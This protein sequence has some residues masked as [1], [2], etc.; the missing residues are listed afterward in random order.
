MLNKRQLLPVLLF[1]LIVLLPACAKNNQ[2]AGRKVPE[3]LLATDCGFDK[4]KC[5]A[6]TP[7]CTYGQQCCVDPND[8][9]R[10][11]C[12]DACACGSNDEFCC[13]GNKCNG[14]AVC[15]NGLCSACGDKNQSCCAAGASCQP[16]LICL[17]NKCAECGITGGPCCPGANK[18]L[19]KEGERSECWNNICASCGFDGNLP[20][21]TGDKCLP[22]QIF[23]GKTCERCGQANQ[24]CCLANSGKGYAC[25]PAV[26]LKCELGFCS[27]EH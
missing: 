5:C 9:A 16:D 8:P 25:D 2:A 21:S 10:N 23:A 22:G 20:C 18:C 26:G 24:P 11:Y 14:N 17:D 19:S 15:V 27:L 4:L 13:A 1:F 7:A 3:V 6:T 12:N